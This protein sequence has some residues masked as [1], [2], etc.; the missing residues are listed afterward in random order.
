MPAR[1]RKYTLDTLTSYRVV[2]DA[3]IHPDGSTIAFVVG[4][5][6]H[7][8]RKNARAN[9]Y[10]AAPG[11]DAPY[12]FTSADASEMHPRW[13][14]D[15]S[16]LAFVSDRAGVDNFQIYLMPRQGGEAHAL[17][18]G[19]AIQSPNRD[20]SMFKW[21]PDGSRI[22]FLQKDSLTPQEMLRRAEGSDEIV[23]EHNHKFT[24]LVIADLATRKTQVVTRGAA[25][26]WEFDWSPDGKEFVLICSA[27]PYEWSWY[28]SWLARV[29]ATGGTPRKLFA[30]PNRQLGHPRWSPDGHHI[31]FVSSLWSDRGIIGGDLYLI[32]SNG[33][34]PRV[35][36]DGYAGT[37]S[38][39][40]WTDAQTI[41]AAGY[42]RGQATLTQFDIH[43][44]H[45]SVW[46]G[47]GALQES[48]TPKFS[49]SADGTIAVVRSDPSSPRE[50]WMLYPTDPDALVWRQVTN[51]NAEFLNIVT[52]DQDV[53]EW[54]SHDGLK[55]QGVLVKPVGA[56]KGKR[57]PLIVQPHGGPTG[58]SANEYLSPLRWAYHLSNRGYAV[59]MPNFRG[60]TGWGIEFAEA[61]LGDMG[62]QDW[63]DIMAGVD[64][65]I[66]KGIADPKRM[67][68][69]GWSYGGFM[70]VWAITQ[71]HRFK[72][73]VAG[74][75]I[76][77][78]LSF[79][80]SSNL[81]GWDKLHYNNA[82]PYERGGVFD[83]FTPIN[84]IG[85]ARTPTLVLQGDQDRDVPP[86]QAYEI[87]RALRDHGVECELVIYPREPHSVTETAHARDLITRVCEWF[88]RHLKP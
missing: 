82:N 48:Y 51:L 59:F 75:A 68:I 8:R 41:L 40:E 9:I 30:R 50:V 27:L 61:N 7:P 88:D 58:I 16:T 43:G 73:A 49:R 28:D 4:D 19:A 31:S 29:P 23:F 64:A 46:T 70:T 74:A 14:P 24:R 52:G 65:L 60:S 10:I 57:L 47:I 53:F 37:L 18:S 77:N 11:S 83:K 2:A 69:G 38:G 63:L 71:T 33:K 17:T 85:N 86:S 72:A 39:I 1:A 45:Q 22:A 67:G 79:H 21:S 78:W 6:T 54:E 80:G 44:A 20:V 13:S 26:V 36:A 81:S 66:N 62:G 32:D 3:Q 84:Y 35:L 15:G 76:G 34:S 5:L 42:L 25:Q 55:L 87:F 12:P 56:K